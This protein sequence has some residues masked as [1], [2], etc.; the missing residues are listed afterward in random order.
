MTSESQIAANRL[1]AQASTGPRTAEGKARVARN[2]AKLGLFAARDLVLPEEQAEYDELRSDLEAEILPATVM[3]RTLAMEILHAT[4]RLRRC[5]LTEASLDPD[6]PEAMDATQATIDR[7]RAHARNNLHCAT[8]DLSRLQTERHL[9]AQLAP[10]APEDLA[11]HQAIAKTLAQDSRRRLNLRKL[12]DLD[13]FEAIINAAAAH[14]DN[15]PPSDPFEAASADLLAHI[16]KQTQSSGDAVQT[17]PFPPPDPVQN[18]DRK[19]AATA[20]PLEAASTEAE[21]TFADCLAF[22]TK[23]TQS[24]GDAVQT[25]PFPPPNPVQNRDR[26]GAATPDPLE[27]VN[28]EAKQTLADFLAFITKQTQFGSPDTTGQGLS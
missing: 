12:N 16:T 20:N 27:S 23:Q 5:A 9:R 22:I 18:R 21:Q 6:D 10:E 7:A 17:D 13:N 2:S 28:T 3:E 8:A 4:W 1:N 24:S 15:A 19:G 11:S 14:V 25:D 26:K